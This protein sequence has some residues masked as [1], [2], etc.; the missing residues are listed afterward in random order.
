MNRIDIEIKLHKG[1]VW[2][3]EMFGA[4]PEDDLLR[5]A[6]VS[7]HDATSLWSPKDHLAHLS[8]IETSFNGMIRRHLGGDRNPVG[9]GS[10]EDGTPRTMEQIMGIVHEMTERWV[11]QQRPKS[12]SE[13]V[14]VG[15]RVRADT[16]GLLAELTDEQLVE[17]LPGAPWADG[18]IG[19]VI[20]VNADHGRTHWQWARDGLAARS[21]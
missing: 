14:A 11:V 15:E 13:V 17:L 19:G 20:G 2:A 8:G 12:L 21:G 7:E 9:I 5:G 3:L 4:L 6:T 1:R 18:T 16:L 10:N